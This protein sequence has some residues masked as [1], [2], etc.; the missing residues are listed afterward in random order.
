M[1]LEVADSRMRSLS[2]EQRD[3]I[4]TNFLLHG[5]DEAGRKDQ[6]TR[7]ATLSDGVGSAQTIEWTDD[8]RLL[9]AVSG[10]THR[11]TVHDLEGREVIVVTDRRYE[12]PLRI[13]P[14]D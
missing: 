8:M 1:V 10:S 4:A 7:Y 14:F 3:Q 6:C 12:Q 9:R 13:R 2:N 11:S 5:L